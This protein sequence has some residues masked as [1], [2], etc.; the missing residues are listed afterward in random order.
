[1]R[2]TLIDHSKNGETTVAQAAGVCYGKPDKDVSRIKRLKQHKHLATMRFAHAVILVE[3]VSVPCQNQ[4]V[5]SAHLDF[6]VQSK[7]Y[8]DASGMGFVY[9]ESLP[10]EAYT[11]IQDS[12]DMAMDTYSDLLELGVAKEDARA[13]LP[14]NTTT[15]MYIAGNCQAWMDMLKL[16]VSK[17]AQ[18]EIREV[19]LRCWEALISCYP[20]IFTDLVYEGKTLKEWREC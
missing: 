4:M 7:R 14:M 3:G 6:L 19:A 5:R 18:A 10:D 11:A 16:R 1:M 8:V 15:D 2:V 9:P 13:I 20:L 17:H 12:V